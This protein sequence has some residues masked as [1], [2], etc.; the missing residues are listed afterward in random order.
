MSP[1]RDASSRVGG[2]ASGAP[3]T[4]I[5]GRGGQVC[6]ALNHSFIPGCRAE[7]DLHAEG[8]VGGG[9]RP[10]KRGATSLF[11]RLKP[12][13]SVIAYILL[14]RTMFAHWQGS[15]PY[16]DAPVL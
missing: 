5:L 7:P 4:R 11:G 13:F 15:L 3:V 6:Q 1:T 10:P 9:W 14:E 16:A 2:R 8:G 12:Y